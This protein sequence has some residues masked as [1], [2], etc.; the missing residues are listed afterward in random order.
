MFLGGFVRFGLVKVGGDLIL[1]DW[2]VVVVFFFKIRWAF[3]ELRELLD[4]FDCF[5][6][7]VV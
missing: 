4:F 2:K 1:V 7:G 6:G 3:E 5:L